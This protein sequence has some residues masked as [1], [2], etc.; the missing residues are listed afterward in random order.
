MLDV[1][2]VKTPLAAH[3]WLSADLSPQT[4][5]D[6]KYMSYVPYA[7]AVGR[8]M[9]TMVCT[10]LDISNAINVVSRYME[11]LEKSHWQAVK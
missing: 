4:D 10:W 8:I 2:P 7:S 9:Y 6:E 5:E 11:R 1:K 3:F